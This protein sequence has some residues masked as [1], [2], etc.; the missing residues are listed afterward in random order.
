[1]L[2][3]LKVHH[4]SHVYREGNGVADALAQFGKLTL[5]STTQN[6]IFFE[7]PPPFISMLLDFDVIGTS[8]NRTVLYPVII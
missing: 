2:H 1:M 7:D 4:L 8:T 6:I 3:E 5:G